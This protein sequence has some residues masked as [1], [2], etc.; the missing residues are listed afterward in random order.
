M[1]EEVET[2]GTSERGRVTLVRNAQ[3]GKRY[4]CK[5]LQGQYPV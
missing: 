5:E 1:L 4:V 2:L 3:T